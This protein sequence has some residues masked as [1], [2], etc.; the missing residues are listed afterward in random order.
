MFVVDA[1][2]VAPLLLHDLHERR[3]DRPGRQHGRRDPDP[4]GRLAEVLRDSMRERLAVLTEAFAMVGYEDQQRVVELAVAS[5][6]VDDPAD[7]AIDAGNLRVVGRNGKSRV[8]RRR[9]VARI[10]RITASPSLRAISRR[11][12]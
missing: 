5:E 10:R 11:A 8:G 9:A 7:L 12:A 6:G 4:L 1:R 3:E 2:E